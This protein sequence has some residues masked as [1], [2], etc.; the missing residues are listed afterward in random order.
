MNEIK[1]ERVMHRKLKFLRFTKNLTKK[2]LEKLH[3][4]SEGVMITST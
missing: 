4:I 1:Y 2:K 3:N